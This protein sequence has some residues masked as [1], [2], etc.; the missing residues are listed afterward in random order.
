MSTPTKT[1]T[2]S[3]VAL[4][5]GAITNAGTIEISGTSSIENDALGNSQLTVD[6]GQILT[7]DGTTVTGGI[8]T[9]SGTIHV[10]ADQDT[11]AQRRGAQL[12]ARSPM[13]ARSRSPAPAA[14]R[15]TRSAIPN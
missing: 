12:A 8:V 13:P 3:G 2:L 5:G 11:D 10:D 4:A 9:D 14:S 15:T 1:L 7:L 6:S